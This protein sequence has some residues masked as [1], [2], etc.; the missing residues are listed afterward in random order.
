MP[1]KRKYLAKVYVVRDLTPTQRRRSYQS[2]C[3]LSDSFRLL[4]RLRFL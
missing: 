2:F 4:V 1:R 3:D